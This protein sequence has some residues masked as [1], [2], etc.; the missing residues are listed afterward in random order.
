MRDIIWHM[1]QQKSTVSSGMSALTPMMAQYQTIKEKYQD[2]LLFYR[3]GDF[4]EMFFQM[5]KWRPLRL[6]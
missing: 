4:Y 5:R 3:M 1:A 2:I 6:E